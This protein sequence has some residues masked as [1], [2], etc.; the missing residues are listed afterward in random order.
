MA[1]LVMIGGVAWTAIEG[2]ALAEAVA[3]RD[4]RIMATGSNQDIQALVRPGT[5]VIELNGRTVTPGFID[6]HTH[7]ISGGFQLSNVDLRDAATP[8][9]FVMRIRKFTESVPSG[10]WITGGNWD[11]ELWG[12]LLPRSDWIDSVTQA[13]PVLVQRLDGHMALANSLALKVGGVTKETEDPPGG[14][15]VRDEAGVPS[16]VLKDQAIA[17]VRKAIPPMTEEEAEQ[18]L[19]SAAQ[20]ALSLGV[21]Q[22]HDMGGWANLDM[23][24]WANLER[25]R[26]VHSAGRLPLRVYSVVPMSSW[27]RMRDYVATHGRGD[28]RLW[29]GG[30]KAFVDGSLGSTT[31]WFHEAYADDPENT[32]LTTTDTT[33]LRN[34][35][36]RADEA[37]LQVIVHAIGDRANDWLLKTYEDIVANN[38]ERDRRFRIEHAQHLSQ[39]AI[40]RFCEQGVIASM[41]PYHAVDDGRWAARRI[42]PQR[43]KQAYAFR[44][45]LDTGAILAFGSDWTV[46][47]LNPI[48]GIDAA[49]T[50][51]TLDGANPD[52]WI[53]EERTSLEEALLAYT[54]GAATAGFSDDRSGSLENGKLAD[55]VVLSEDIFDEHTHD[56]GDVQV[57][58]T[59]VEG[60]V[61]YERCF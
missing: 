1:D 4:G 19:E 47:P 34:W 24:G 57:D 53:P 13:H 52:G 60:E 54:A 46:A 12:G 50:R 20:H 9:E 30:V 32:G 25:Y 48:L 56:V 21:T 17:L 26:R 33:E 15:I 16:G 10:A 14:S 31:A 11:H 42:G 6:A 35:I 5:R 41:Q 40:G 61:A 44:S 51:R 58:M 2:S 29:W 22:V 37:G 3:V 27:R 28:D 43:V 23:M 18:A 55:L 36:E 7:F 8:E 45:I 39:S 49:V 59:V 38:G